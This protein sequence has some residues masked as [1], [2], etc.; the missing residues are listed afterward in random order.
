MQSPLLSILVPVYNVSPYIERCLDSLIGQTYRNIE[1]ICVDDG[2]TDDSFEILREYEKKD[3]RV[4]IIH[5][6]NGGL[7]S[8]RKAA[9]EMA[10]G[11]YVGYVDSDDWIEENMYAVLMHY[12]IDN[13]VDIV[14]SGHYR[15]Y[16]SHRIK[17]EPKLRNGVYS[18]EQIVNEGFISTINFTQM[19][20]SPNLVDKL[21]KKEILYNNQMAVPEGISD[22]EDVACT[23]PTILNCRTIGIIND[24]MYHY[25]LRDDSISF[26]TRN[27]SYEILFDY[28]EKRIESNNYAE[29]MRH[30]MKMLKYVYLMYGNPE[31]LI[32]WENGI[33]IP[34]GK[35]KENSR[36]IIYGSGR[37]GKQLNLILCKGTNLEVLGQVDKYRKD[38]C[39]LDLDILTKNDYDAILIGILNPDVIDE[40]RSYLL[41]LNIPDEKIMSIELNLV[42]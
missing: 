37:F 38:E 29:Q 16:P 20:I 24:C 5:K 12:I 30:Q 6:E 32:K 41:G 35:I 13:N 40:V 1:I 22:G 9:L 23:W 14:C 7:V 4:K 11:M 15:D 28:L 34:F 33:L 17:K 26:T 31:M 27:E 8:A 39:L 42:E 19:N 21:F 2:S 18:I 3:S 10:E 36:V 25:C